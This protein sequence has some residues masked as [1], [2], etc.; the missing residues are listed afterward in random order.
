MVQRFCVTDFA[1]DIFVITRNQTSIL[2]NPLYQSENL[3]PQKSEKSNMSHLIRDQYFL[4]VTKFRRSSRPFLY[5]FS[6]NWYKM[7]IAFCL[8]SFIFCWEYFIPPHS[9]TLSITYFTFSLLLPSF[10]TMKMIFLRISLLTLFKVYIS[11]RVS[12]FSFISFPVG[13]P[14]LSPP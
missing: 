3:S 12:F 10:F 11:G 5:G 6:G 8:K 9:T 14:T 4:S 7:S 1:D 13:F 2:A